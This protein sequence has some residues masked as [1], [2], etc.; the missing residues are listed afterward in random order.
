[1]QFP[2]I[3][4]NLSVRRFGAHTNLRFGA[5]KP[6]LLSRSPF[7]LQPECA[8]LRRTQ[9]PASAHTNP[10][11][12]AHKSANM[13]T[14]NQITH[15]RRYQGYDYSRGGSIFISFHLEPR[16][17][18]FGN[19]TPDGVMNLS[20]AGL[21]LDDTISIECQKHPELII[22]SFVIMPEHLHYRMTFPAGLSKPLYSI[23]RFVQEI[24][25]WS[26][27]KLE[28]TGIYINWQKNYHDYLCLSKAI[29][30]RVDEYI[31]LNPLK[32]ALMH[33]LNP[34]MRVLEPLQSPLLPPFEWWSGVGNAELLSGRYPLL[35]VS[36]SRR[37]SEFDFQ[38]IVYG[39]MNECRRGMIPVSTFISPAEIYLYQCLCNENIPMICAVPDQLK[40]I[41]KPRTDQTVLFA[42]N[43]LL[44]LSHLQEGS[45]SRNSV[46]HALNDDLVQIANAS[47]GKALYFSPEGVTCM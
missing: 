9:I 29:N 40:T 44:L 35:A 38:T 23:G 19:I 21:I 45:L 13:D 20:P 36:L 2:S 5:H 3:P 7:P 33:G 24:K 27:A 1:M 43:R 22:R 18:I 34:P 15:F 41:Y 25:R 4:I 39:I 6:P 12:G 14:Q 26:K 46:W 28:D 8:P 17:G 37:L 16:Y 47:N 31:R 32:W 30:E 10:R 11:F 42:Q